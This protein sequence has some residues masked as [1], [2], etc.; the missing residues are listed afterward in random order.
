M[1]NFSMVPRKY[2]YNESAQLNT[3]ELNRRYFISYIYKKSARHRLERNIYG[4][5]HKEYNF[6]CYRLFHALRDHQ[7][8]IQSKHY[9]YIFDVTM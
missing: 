5:N 3:Q 9:R 8:I 2:K 4:L 1:F 7:A 6:F